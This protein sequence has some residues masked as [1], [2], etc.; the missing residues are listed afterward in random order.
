MRRRAVW[1][2]S[3]I[4]DISGFALLSIIAFV[5][6]KRLGDGYTARSPK[7]GLNLT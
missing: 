3:D 5:N 1:H 4:R 2:Y 7:R 6:K